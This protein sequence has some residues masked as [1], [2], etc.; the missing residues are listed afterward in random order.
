MARKKKK[1]QV[2][3]QT[4]DVDTH[5]SP[6]EDISNDTTRGHE[7]E[8]TAVLEAE[9]SKIIVPVIHGTHADSLDCCRH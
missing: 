1:S 5:A 8:A 4:T 2:K 6:V 7:A 9:Q 3:E